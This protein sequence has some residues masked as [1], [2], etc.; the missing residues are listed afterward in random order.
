MISFDSGNTSIPKISREKSRKIVKDLLLKRDE[1]G[2]IDVDQT[3]DIGDN[4][5]DL[6]KQEFGD[7]DVFSKAFY[8]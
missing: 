4:S 8:E 2:F 6:F 1:L 3:I 5:S 7:L